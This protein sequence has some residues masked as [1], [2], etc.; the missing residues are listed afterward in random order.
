MSRKFLDDHISI[1]NLRAFL[2]S[3]TPAT[4]YDPGHMFQDLGDGTIFVNEGTRQGSNFGHKY[5]NRADYLEQ[6]IQSPGIASDLD[7]A[8]FSQAANRLYTGANKQFSLVGTNAVTT[9]SVLTAGGGVK[10]TTTTASGDQVIASPVAAINSVEV[11]PFN[12]GALTQNKPI[13]ET[14][15]KTG[16]AVTLQTIWAGLKLTNTSVTATDANQA[17]F[18]FQDVATL[19][20]GLGQ[21]QCITGVSAVNT[22]QLSGVTV[23]LA[24]H[25]HLKITVDANRVPRF[26]IN[27]VLV[28]TGPAMTTAITL[29]PFVGVQTGTTAAKTLEVRAIR[30]S[31]DFV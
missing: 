18:R 27:G 21:F 1:K 3:T 7:P 24:T 16:A 12:L 9:A 23:A 15:I 10:F 4:I 19:A 8:A 28:A 25:Y 5:V 31:K 22:T 13:F 6:F 29:K 14:V 26:Y 11:S 20:A 17:F 2:P 30:L